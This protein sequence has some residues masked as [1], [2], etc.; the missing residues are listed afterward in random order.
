MKFLS[1]CTIYILQLTYALEYD[2]Y[3]ALKTLY[4]S[5]QGSSWSWRMDYTANGIPWN[6]T[7]TEVPEDPC[8]PPLWQ[9]VTC[10]ALMTNVLSLDLPSY[11]LT[12]PIPNDYFLTN[13]LDS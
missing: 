8:E 4:D 11:N 13:Y 6:F 2:E 10:N 3:M 7:E 5:C 12:G 1:L 9:G